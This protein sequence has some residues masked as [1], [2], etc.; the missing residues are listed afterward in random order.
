MSSCANNR[1]RSLAAYPNECKT[2]YQ[3]QKLAGKLNLVLVFL[4]SLFWPT[5][6]SWFFRS[7]SSARAT[8]R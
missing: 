3:G 1:M 7:T 5:V 8:R 4:L 6:C 2:Y